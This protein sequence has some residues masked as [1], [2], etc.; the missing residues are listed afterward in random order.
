MLLVLSRPV[1]GSGCS[2]RYSESESTFLNSPVI[3]EL[4]DRLP[5]LLSL[6]PTAIF[7]SCASIERKY[8][9]RQEPS[10]LPSLKVQWE[11][12]QNF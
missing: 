10:L 5:K 9:R 4:V 11:R 6:L 7:L 12:G 1:V 2:P 3:K 8:R